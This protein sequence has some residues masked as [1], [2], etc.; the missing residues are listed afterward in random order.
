MIKHQDTKMNISLNGMT[1]FSNCSASFASSFLVF[2]EE[3]T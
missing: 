3:L 2:D 1:G